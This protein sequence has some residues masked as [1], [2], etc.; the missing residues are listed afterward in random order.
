MGLGFLE[1]SPAFFYD[2]LTYLLT[3]RSAYLRLFLDWPHALMTFLRPVDGDA[4]YSAPNVCGFRSAVLFT[5]FVHF[6]TWSTFAIVPFRMATNERTTI[7]SFLWNGEMNF[8]FLL[9]RNRR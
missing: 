5:L 6:E 2:L 9:R 1:F 4:S 3:L 8:F 7:S